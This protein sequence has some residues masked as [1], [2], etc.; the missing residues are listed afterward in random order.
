[1][2]IIDFPKW[3][4][5]YRA[6]N[7]TFPGEYQGYAYLQNKDCFKLMESMQEDA[8]SNE[9]YEACREFV[10]RSVDSY[11]YEQGT[12]V[13]ISKNRENFDNLYGTDAEN[14]F[15]GGFRECKVGDNYVIYGFDFD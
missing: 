8:R 15:R 7:G 4:F 10:D 14:H 1:M 12:I 11:N 2:L 13:G 6:V 5:D 9:S 3:A